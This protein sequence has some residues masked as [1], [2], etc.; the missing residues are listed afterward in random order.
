MIS[1]PQRA[2]TLR[3]T[4]KNLAATDW[5]DEP[6][7]VRLDQDPS[8]PSNGSQ[9]RNAFALLQQGLAVRADYI[10]FL[11]DDLQ[12]NQFIRHNLYS[13]QPLLNREITLASLFNPGFQPVACDVI[14]HSLIVEPFQMFGSQA[15][16]LSKTAI[17]R[18]LAHW[19]E[20]QE[21][22]D[23][24]MPRLIGQRGKPIYCHAP[25]LVQHRGRRSTF[26]HGFFQAV[27]FDPRW[28]AA[29]VPS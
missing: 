11:E 13:W 21:P 8:C 12:F 20:I 6:V 5:G 7:Q 16:L 19:E 27:D 2:R 3:Q 4:L 14:N 28:K 23:L 9:R 10:L 26:G 1:C 17:R 25:S 29:D 22:V 24:V 18:I 15:L